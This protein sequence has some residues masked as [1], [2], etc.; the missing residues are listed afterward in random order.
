MSELDIKKTY[1]VEHGEV[2]IVLTL[3][4]RTITCDN[5]E[6]DYQECVNELLAECVNA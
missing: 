2:H 1:K 5:S 4:N 6:V 3:G